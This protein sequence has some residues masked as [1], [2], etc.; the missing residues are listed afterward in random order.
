MFTNVPWKCILTWLVGFLFHFFIHKH[1]CT[2][3]AWTNLTN[4]STNCSITS[5]YQEHL[6]DKGISWMPFKP[7]MVIYCSKALYEIIWKTNKRLGT[8][9][10]STKYQRNPFQCHV[11]HQVVTLCAFLHK[12]S[13]ESCFFYV[14]DSYKKSFYPL[15]VDVFIPFRGAKKRKNMHRVVKR[16]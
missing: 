6:F 3:N 15:L 2:C 8:C 9:N 13:I 14:L 11:A 4:K 10:L 7:L 1:I 16:N 5:T 12:V